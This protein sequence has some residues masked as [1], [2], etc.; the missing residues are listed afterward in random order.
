MVANVGTKT[1][2][3]LSSS[4]RN[5]AIVL[6]LP[7]QFKFWVLNFNR[8]RNTQE[9]GEHPA[10]LAHCLGGCWRKT[11]FQP[12]SEEDIAEL[13]ALS[14][15]LDAPWALHTERL[16]RNRRETGD[17]LPVW[18]RPAAQRCTPR[19]CWPCCGNSRRIPSA[20]A[21]WATTSTS[22]ATD[23]RRWPSGKSS[24]AAKR[25]PRQTHRTRSR[26]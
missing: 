15:R 16:A 6:P 4:A 24:S 7:R 9:W 10:T 11:L 17:T 13:E 3:R 12:F 25:A 14:A 18:G 1:V 21:T 22:P 5:A 20:W 19:L 8:W 2:A 23:T 26:V